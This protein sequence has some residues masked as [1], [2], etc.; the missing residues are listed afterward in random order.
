LGSHPKHGP[1]VGI[2][3]VRREPQALTLYY[4]IRAF[5]RETVGRDAEASTRF[6][7]SAEVLG[8]TC[9]PEKKPTKVWLRSVIED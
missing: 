9:G 5:R 2:R 8:A 3:A 7:L 1:G 4:R 6:V